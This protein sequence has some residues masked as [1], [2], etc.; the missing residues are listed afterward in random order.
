MRTTL[1][2]FA[3]TFLASCNQ[4][5]T[6]SVSRG[7]INSEAPYLWTS[8][9][10]KQ[11]RISSAFDVRP[12][13]VTSIQAVGN[14]WS[15]AVENKKTFFTY[16][17]GA[18]E[19]TIG[20]GSTSALNDG[21]LGVYKATT[22]PYPD[23][24]DALAVTQIF[25]YR[26]NVGTSSEYVDIQEADIIM[27]Y[28]NFSFDDPSI[29]YDYDLRTVMLHEMGHFLGLSHKSK[30]SDRNASVMFP[31][32]YNHE[33][34]QNPKLV[35]VGDIASKYGVTLSGSGS[36]AIAGNAQKYEPNGPGTAVKI[37]LELRANGDCVH[38]ED[39]AETLRHHAENI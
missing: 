23:Y 4:S 11:L 24:P 25:A 34:K 29:S 3:L 37:I 16:S 10:P 15:T 19:K 31:S 36:A 6:G 2:I 1:F 26:Y 14:A 7:N 38:Y 9:F 33:I 8:S 27:N 22:W 30:Y 13:D 18:T 32:I 35:D 21:V 39:G 5:E 12:A 28:Q 17:T 20:L